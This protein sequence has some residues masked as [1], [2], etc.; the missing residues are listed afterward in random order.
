MSQKSRL[1][2]IIGNAIIWAAV[3]IATGLVLSGTDADNSQQMSVLMI[4]IV[5]WL[6]TN[7]AITRAAKSG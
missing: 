7:M 4:Q 1:N 2:P 3:M 5:G 6:M